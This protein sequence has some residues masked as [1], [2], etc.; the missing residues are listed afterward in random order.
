VRD[1][2]LVRRIMRARAFIFCGVAAGEDMSGHKSRL[3]RLANRLDAPRRARL[4]TRG[5]AAAN[6]LWARR[7]AADGAAGMQPMEAV[8]VVSA[9]SVGVMAPETVEDGGE[10]AAEEFLVE[11]PGEEDEEEEFEGFPWSGE[12]EGA[13][14][15]LAPEGDMP[16]ARLVDADVPMASVETGEDFLREI[17]GE[18][19]G[20]MAVGQGAEADRLWQAYVPLSLRP[21]WAGEVRRALEEKKMKMGV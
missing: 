20:L 8:V 21:K 15:E 10:E 12:E 2:P 14:E 19:G 6:A 7:R 17:C 1:S 3:R 9:A 11:G 5:R 13:E 4:S 16:V 18:I